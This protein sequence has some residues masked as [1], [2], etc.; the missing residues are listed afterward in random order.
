[1]DWKGELRGGVGEGKRLHRI[2]R[3]KRTDAKKMKC[4]SDSSRRS[5][6]F[7]ELPAAEW[8]SSSTEKTRGARLR[9]TCA[10]R[11]GEPERWHGSFRARKTGDK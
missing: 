7:E 3:E 6:I 1:M 5:K 4:E 9:K 11:Q 8:I 2:S 10:Y